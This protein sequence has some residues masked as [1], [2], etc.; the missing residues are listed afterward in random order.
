MLKLQNFGH[1]M[2]K[3]NSPE[4]ILML[5]KIEER[6]RRGW[7]RMRCLNGIIDSMDMSL[8]Q[9]W[10]LEKDRE[11]WHAAVHGAEKSQTLLGDWTVGSG[12]YW[13]LDHLIW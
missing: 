8:S 5:E 12:L 3:A 6:R 10:E 2:Q 11:V 7:Q 4:R 13:V 9:L 1:Q